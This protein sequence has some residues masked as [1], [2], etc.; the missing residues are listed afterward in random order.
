MKA[1]KILKSRKAVSPDGI[2]PE[3]LKANTATSAEILLPI[4]ATVWENEEVPRVEKRISGQTTI[5]G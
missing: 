5:E 2:P 1:M 4:L 3:A